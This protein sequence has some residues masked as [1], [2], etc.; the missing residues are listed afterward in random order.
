[1]ISSNFLFIGNKKKP[2]YMIEFIKKKHLM[3]IY[4]PDKYS[5]KSKDF[6]DKYYLGETLEIEYEKIYYIKKNLV[7]YSKTEKECKIV[8]DILPEMLIKTKK[9][10]ILVNESVT[11]SEKIEN[12]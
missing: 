1:M 2:F 12:K 3:V 10:Y 4:R 5:E 8:S 7:K 11:Y 9:R 6:V